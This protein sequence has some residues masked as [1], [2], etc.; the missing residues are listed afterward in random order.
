M[1]KNTNTITILRENFDSETDFKNAIKDAIAVL[2][3]NNYVMTVR[4]EEK[5]AG[6]VAIDY[7]YGNEGFGD[8]YPRWLLPE[9][10][11]SIYF[12]RRERKE[13]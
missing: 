9:E 10:W 4:W 3:D 6:I 13:D 2:L 7:N 5:G 8:Y 12:D 11:E 1:N